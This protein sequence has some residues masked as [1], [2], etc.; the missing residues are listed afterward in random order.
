LRQVDPW[1]YIAEVIAQ[2]RKGIDP[3]KIAHA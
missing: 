2:G 3:P 1:E